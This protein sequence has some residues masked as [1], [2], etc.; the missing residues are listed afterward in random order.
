MQT[1][2]QRLARGDQTAFAELYDACADRCHHYLTAMLGS[3]EAADDVLQ[4]TFL[5][6]V[7][8]RRKLAAVTNVIAYVFV[9]CRNEA[10]R[11]RAHQARRDEQR[12]TAEDLFVEAERGSDQRDLA[13][14]VTRG[15]ET[16][17][18]EQREVVQLKMYAGLTFREI[19]EITEVPLQTA[20]T[21]YRSA[22]ESLRPWLARQLS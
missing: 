9:I 7:R 19:A 20:A 6:L 17:S 22:L 21:R 13:D 11:H 3:R 4:E 8:Q 14:L 10:F 15:L 1:L 16:L 18:L 5:R 2:G 12:L